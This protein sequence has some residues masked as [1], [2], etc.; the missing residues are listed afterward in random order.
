MN[1][2]NVETV[3]GLDPHI[4][5]EIHNIPL[6]LVRLIILLEFGTSISIFTTEAGGGLS[7]ITVTAEI[8]C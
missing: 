3:Q 4:I 2:F 5:L 6:Y 1:N 7:H 8:F